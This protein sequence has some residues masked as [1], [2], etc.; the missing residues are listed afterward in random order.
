MKAATAQVFSLEKSVLGLPSGW[1]DG[2]VAETCGSPRDSRPGRKS[3]RCGPRAPLKLTRQQ[4]GEGEVVH[5][6]RVAPCRIGKHRNP[7][8]GTKIH[9]KHKIIQKGTGSLTFLGVFALLG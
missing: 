8:N 9:Q 1:K 6:E 5:W 7:Q 3:A 4:V 2:E